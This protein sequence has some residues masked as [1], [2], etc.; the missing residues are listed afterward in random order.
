MAILH[1]KCDEIYQYPEGIG[2]SKSSEKL[3]GNKL[4]PGNYGKSQ[5][6]RKFVTRFAETGIHDFSQFFTE[7]VM[8]F[9]DTR[10]LVQVVAHL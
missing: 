2:S 4:I 3:Y 8:N 1:R 9:A 7:D 6:F 5:L 10:G